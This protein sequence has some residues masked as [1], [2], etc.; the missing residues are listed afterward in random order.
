MS[1]CL[2]T[3]VDA[4]TA[5]HFCSPPCQSI[6][7]IVTRSTTAASLSQNLHGF[8]LFA[9]P[10]TRVRF[11]KTTQSRCM[12]MVLLC[13]VLRWKGPEVIIYPI[14]V[15]DIVSIYLNS[16]YLERTPQLAEMFSLS[17]IVYPVSGTECLPQRRSELAG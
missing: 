11:G 4:V 8:S 1:R 5:I 7:V 12:Q 6:V 10:Y 2:Q 13:R 3:R 16:K 14:V 9:Q 15:S 17:N